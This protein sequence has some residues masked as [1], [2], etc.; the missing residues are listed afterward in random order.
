MRRSVVRRLRDPDGTRRRRRRVAPPGVSSWTLALAFVASL[1]LPLITWAA[2][3]DGVTAWERDWQSSAQNWPA[4]TMTARRGVGSLGRP[5]GIVVVAAGV[6]IVARRCYRHWPPA[7]FLALTVLISGLAV[8][9]GVAAGQPWVERAAGEFSDAAARTAYP[10]QVAAV[11]AALWWLTALHARSLVPN[12]S[13]IVGPVLVVVGASV[14]VGQVV[15]G[16]AYPLDV[17]AGWAVGGLVAALFAGISAPLHRWGRHTRRTSIAAMHS[18]SEPQAGRPPTAPASQPAASEPDPAAN[19][20]VSD[21]ARNAGSAAALF[22]RPAIGDGAWVPTAGELPDDA[23]VPDA[24]GRGDRRDSGEGGVDG[25]GTATP[26]PTPSGAATTARTTPHPARR[27]P[28]E[29]PLD[30]WIG[31]IAA[32]FDS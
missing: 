26:R 21:T 6:G 25:P 2:L 7:A 12:A 23:A 15:G 10:A 22:H 18:A 11:G 5:V 31:R 9:G 16:D 29:D 24:D 1:T 14:G 8:H 28:D 4:W 32:F 30:G 27:A 17:A 3:G 19:P 13:T 20:Q